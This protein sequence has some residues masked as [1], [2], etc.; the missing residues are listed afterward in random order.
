MASVRL[1]D[2]RPAPC[3][4]RDTTLTVQLYADRT[5]VEAELAFCPNPDGAAGPLVLRVESLELL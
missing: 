5:L 3:L 2:Y 4:I 1:A